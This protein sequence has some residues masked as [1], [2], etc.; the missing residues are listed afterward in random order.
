MKGEIMKSKEE[1]EQELS[2]L[3]VEHYDAMALAEAYRNRQNKIQ[4]EIMK[5][6]DELHALSEKEPA[7]KKEELPEVTKEKEAANS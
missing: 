3:K 1:L 6:A 7:E 4:E 5:I 2:V